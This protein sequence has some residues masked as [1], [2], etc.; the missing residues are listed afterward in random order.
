MSPPGALPAT[1]EGMV[2]AY[3]DHIRAVQ[4]TGPYHLLGW[5]F[6]GAVAHAIAVRLQHQ[7]ESVGPH[8]GQS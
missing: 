5:S 1:L 4:P 6:G 3:L 2:T 7:G 8:P